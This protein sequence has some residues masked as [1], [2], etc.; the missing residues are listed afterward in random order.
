MHTPQC[1]SKQSITIELPFLWNIVFFFRENA[2][3]INQPKQKKTL[4]K[5][6][7]KHTRHCSSVNQNWIKTKLYLYVRSWQ[8]IIGEGEGREGV[9]FVNH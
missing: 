5:Q 2:H 7:V 3:L 4:F 8:E 6:I 9:R 1:T